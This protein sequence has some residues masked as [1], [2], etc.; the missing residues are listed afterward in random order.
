MNLNG[1]G[2]AADWMW[3]N[4]RK[5]GF[6]ENFKILTWRTKQQLGDRVKRSSLGEEKRWRH[7]K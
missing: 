7:E 3:K 5:E 4:D 1:K 2:Q 6:Q